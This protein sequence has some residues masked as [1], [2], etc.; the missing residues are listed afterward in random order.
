MFA[1]SEPAGALFATLPP[2]HYA[3]VRHQYIEKIVLVVRMQVTYA[4]A[5]AEVPYC[6]E[7]LS[8]HG[9]EEAYPLTLRMLRADLGHHNHWV[10]RGGE[11]L[12]A[13]LGRMNMTPHEIPRLRETPDER[14][15]RA[16]LG[17]LGLR[18]GSADDMLTV[19]R[20]VEHLRD[21]ALPPG[22]EDAYAALAMARRIGHALR[23]AEYLRGEDERRWARAARAAAG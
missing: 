9:L 5:P 22:A 21:H 12:E 20:A 6:L 15:E 17:E 3:R 8:P 4:G 14:A 10:A 23:R 7:S 19:V 2:W 13:V 1:L 11:W 18:E 16:A